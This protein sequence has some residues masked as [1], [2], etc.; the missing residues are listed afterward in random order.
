MTAPPFF[1]FVTSI[2]WLCRS[3]DVVGCETP[4]A[5][6]L[7][8]I[9]CARHHEPYLMLDSGVKSYESRRG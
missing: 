8:M 4:R 2:R 5:L 7:T 3:H 9:G 1:W 6:S